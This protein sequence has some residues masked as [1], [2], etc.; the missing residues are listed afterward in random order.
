MSEIHL[1]IAESSS[2][3]KEYRQSERIDAY[4]GF[5][6]GD[7]RF[8]TSS[9]LAKDANICNST[10]HIDATGH[11]CCYKYMRLNNGKKA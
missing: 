9:D 10:N 11:H 7:T 8:E 3:E 4:A 1:S 5:A 6:P 2:K